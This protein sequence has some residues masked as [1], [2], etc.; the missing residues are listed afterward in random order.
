MP[1]PVTL[2]ANDDGALSFY[3]K[4]DGATELPFELADG[5]RV[6]EGLGGLLCIFGKPGSLGMSLDAALMARIIR[7]VFDKRIAPVDEK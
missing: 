2:Y 4:D 7:P 3:R 1:T 5:Y 6:G